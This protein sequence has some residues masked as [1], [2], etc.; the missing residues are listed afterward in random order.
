MVEGPHP[1]VLLNG[2][3]GFLRGERQC[4]PALGGGRSFGATR[5]LA[6]LGSDSLVAP[7]NEAVRP[8]EYRNYTVLL[9]NPHTLRE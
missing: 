1:P 2:T 5:P 7:P 3:S 8:G 4:L 6:A 9:G